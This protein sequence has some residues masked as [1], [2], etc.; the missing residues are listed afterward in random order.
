MKDTIGGLLIL[1]GL[2][3]VGMGIW[4]L[5]FGD[6]GEAWKAML[7]GGG[8]IVAGYY[9]VTRETA[10][11]AEQGCSEAEVEP[12]VPSD[13]P[14]PADKRFTI[15]QTGDDGVLDRVIPLL[16]ADHRVTSIIEESGRWHSTPDR[17]DLP[18]WFA[19]RTYCK[20]DDLDG[21]MEELGRLIESRLGKEA[22]SK[23][24]I[25]HY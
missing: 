22:A 3:I 2:L 23:V 13:V 25:R 12:T 8:V 21:L 20:T 19:L 6:G 14:A 11:A 9:V 10:A 1:F 7:T 15:I 17:D 5:V 16:E 4:E 18:E 24:Q